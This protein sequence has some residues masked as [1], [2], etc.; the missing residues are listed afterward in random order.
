MAKKKVKQKK[1]IKSKK[2]GL[3]KGNKFLIPKYIEPP[4]TWLERIW[5]RLN[6]YAF[7]MGDE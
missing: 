4:E 3:I 7:Y 5:R 1:R 2:I 6:E